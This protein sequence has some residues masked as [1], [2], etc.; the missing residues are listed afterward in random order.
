M[1][2]STSPLRT[3]AH[4]PLL[5]RAGS[6]LALYRIAEFGPWVAIL[7]FAYEQ[8]GATTTGVVSLA[9]LTPTALCAPLAG[10]LI[11]RYGASSVLV[12]GYAMQAAGHGARRRRRCSPERQPVVSY[13][14]AA[15]TATVL[16]VT[17]PAHA[18]VSPGIA[19]TTEQLVALNAI[20]GWILS[21][22]LVVAPG[23]G[24]PDPRGGGSGSGVRRRSRS[25][26]RRPPSCVPAPRPRAAALPRGRPG[27]AAAALAE[28]RAALHALRTGGA[29]VEVLLVLT[30]TFVT[31]GAFDVLAV[32]LAVGVLD[33]GG[34]GAG[35]LTALYGGGAVIGAATSFLL[36][37][38]SRI[39]PVVVAAAFLG[40]AAFV[41]LGLAASLLAALVP[42]V[43]AGVSRSLLEVSGAT[44][45]QRVTPTA[46]LARVFAL[47]E[48][49]DDG[50]L[51]AR[52]G[53][54]GGAHCP[55]RRGARADRRRGDRAAA[56]ARPPSPTR[57]RRRGR[58]GAGGR[59]C[60]PAVVAGLSPLPAPAL[61][62][63]AHALAHVSAL[64]GTKIVTEGEH[65]DCY[66]AIADGSVEVTKDDRHVATLDRGE[67]FGEIALLRDVPRT[68][69]VTAKTDAELLVIERDAF[70]VAVTGHADSAMNAG[71]I[72]AE[73]LAAT[74][75]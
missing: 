35:Y 48:G 66:Y 38:R 22:G 12:V 26:S 43:V 11:D 13:A 49:L 8:G 4:D 1:A 5:L 31:V 52:V 57:P 53:P 34:S 29:T 47:K 2:A 64:A 73:R 24:R 20:T 63:I 72:V 36:V 45:L 51:G 74:G 10:P 61:E 25:A 67:G 55:R 46:L 21:V 23:A 6:A 44:L 54:R 39:V 59:N 75:A 28:V 9:L 37:G 27:R 17:H 33:L 60:A 50:G 32:A 19:R 71:S 7:V 40:G 16:T 62:G 65:G 68:A 58:D 30:A 3:L 14:L 56:R 15:I 41:A 69:S 70:L 18:V 42:V